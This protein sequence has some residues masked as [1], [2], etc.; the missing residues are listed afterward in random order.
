MKAVLVDTALEQRLTSAS[1]FETGLL[2]GQ[3]FDPSRTLLLH[4]IPTPP[5]PDL[6][7]LTS[8]SSDASQWLIAHSVQLDR[9]TL[10][11]L[12]LLGLYVRTSPDELR[13]LDASGTL[14]DVLYALPRGSAAAGERFV[15]KSAGGKIACD[16]YAGSWKEGGK[17]KAVGVKVQAL[18][19]SLVE[20]RCSLELDWVCRV[21]Q[22]SGSSGQLTAAVLQAG[23]KLSDTLKA[24]VV[25]VDGQRPDYAAPLDGKGADG[26]PI[27]GAPKRERSE[28]VDHSAAGRAA[29]RVDMYIPLHLLTPS[30]P[31]APPSAA[32]APS[33]SSSFIHLR[34]SLMSRAFVHPRSTSGDAIAAIQQDLCAS[35][36]HRLTLLIDEEDEEEE[37]GEEGEG[38]KHLG[39]RVILDLGDGLRLADYLQDGED[40]RDALCR[41]Q[42]LTGR[43]RLT[44][45]SVLDVEAPAVVV[46]AAF[47]ERKAREK[48]RSEK[49]DDRREEKAR[50]VTAAREAKAKPGNTDL[51]VTPLVIAAVGSD[52]GG[53]SS[54]T[55]L[56]GVFAALLLA[57]SVAFW[58]QLR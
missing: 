15:V 30:Q 19:G 27:S 57:V 7:A 42:E 22:L 5:P 49:K 13:T 43:T 9:M 34:G 4:A 45:E 38:V 14:R 16:C 55:L 36:L 33:S 50:P 3:S 18:V 51:A 12:S 52:S 24:A 46:E 26:K 10:G 37:W 35:L 28:A 41:V 44:R 20:F 53:S 25:T 21:E 58:L 23:A 40:E 56:V 32:S 17:G 11:G 29:R 39:R 8:L 1:T 47:T 6:T 2:L 31:A 48:T 54:S